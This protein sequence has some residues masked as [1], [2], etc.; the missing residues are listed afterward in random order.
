MTKN[1]EIWLP[2]REK[3]RGEG[4]R[5]RQEKYNNSNYGKRN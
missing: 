5:G 4:V 1:I 3:E 2:G